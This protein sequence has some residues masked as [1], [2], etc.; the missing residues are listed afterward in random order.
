MTERLNNNLSYKTMELDHSTNQILVLLHNWKLTG[1][2][3]H[4]CD[5]LT[6]ESYDAASTSSKSEEQSAWQRLQRTCL[7]V[8]APQGSYVDAI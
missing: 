8:A 3:L 6:S 7:M 4:F 5:R 2:E 1:W